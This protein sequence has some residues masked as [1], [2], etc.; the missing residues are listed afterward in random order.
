MATPPGQGN[1]FDHPIAESGGLIEPSLPSERRAV[2]GLARANPSVSST[3][4]FCSG[5]ASEARNRTTTPVC[6]RHHQPAKQLPALAAQALTVELLALAQQS[7]SRGC[8]LSRDGSPERTRPSHP[9][10]RRR[11]QGG[12]SA[13]ERRAR[14]QGLL[15]ELPR[16][17][18]D[19]RVA[20]QHKHPFLGRCPPGHASSTTAGTNLDSSLAAALQ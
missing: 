2:A 5:R 12:G 10:L 6:Q 15:G 19:H 1:L 3:S 4:V 9:S 14:L 11:N 7:P 18:H 17:L 8:H 13:L 20:L 16:S